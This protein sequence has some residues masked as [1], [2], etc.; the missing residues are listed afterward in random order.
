MLEVPCVIYSSKALGVQRRA[1]M[2]LMLKVRVNTENGLKAL[3]LFRRRE[4]KVR[5]TTGIDGVRWVYKDGW[6]RFLLHLARPRAEL[7]RVQERWLE[8]EVEVS[9]SGSLSPLA[10]L[11]THPPTMEERRRIQLEIS[12]ADFESLVLYARWEPNIKG[13]YAKE[14]LNLNG[15]TE[16]VAVLHRG[17]EGAVMW[18][19]LPCTL[20]P[21]EYQVFLK[22]H[23]IRQRV[24]ENILRV[25]LNGTTQEFQWHQTRGLSGGGWVPAPVFVAHRPGRLL[26]VRGL[27]VGGSRMDNPPEKVLR[28]G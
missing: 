22:P 13:W 27:Q 14:F 11:Y 16:T 6:E 7:L 8:R 23:Y 2:L 24:K 28:Y 5:L 19:A 12:A 10:E 15:P 17:N 4:L 25:T 26:K 3:R 1:I 21:D 9:Y 20:P 18:T